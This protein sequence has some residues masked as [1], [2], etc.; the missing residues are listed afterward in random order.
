[1]AIVIP[2]DLRG[3]LNY[4]SL[5]IRPVE[6]VRIGKPKTSRYE[7]GFYDSGDGFAATH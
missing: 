3:T 7:A 2:G 4:G 1:M 6:T 5:V